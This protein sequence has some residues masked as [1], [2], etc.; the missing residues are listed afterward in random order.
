MPGLTPLE[1]GPGLVVRHAVSQ[2]YVRYREQLS[3]RPPVGGNI[4]VPVEEMTLSVPIDEPSSVLQIFRC[5]VLLFPIGAR[6]LQLRLRHGSQATVHQ[7]AE[8]DP[9]V[10]TGMDGGSVTLF[11]AWPN[12]LPGSRTFEIDVRLPVNTSWD[13]GPTMT[14]L[15]HA[16]AV[17]KR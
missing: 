13:Y 17:L 9:T 5:S 11:R 2:G 8:R 6:Q 12:V 1:W 7:T 14:N 3:S 10:I 16:L 15:R 4:W